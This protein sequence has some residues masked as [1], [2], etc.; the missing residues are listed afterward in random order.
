MLYNLWRTVRS[1]FLFFSDSK[2]G[3]SSF[4]T[5]T[6][7]DARGFGQL[8]RTSFSGQADQR[9]AHRSAGGA[10]VG[11]DRSWH[12]NAVPAYQVNI[13]VPSNFLSLHS[14][15]TTVSQLFCIHSPSRTVTVTEIT[16]G[17]SGQLGHVPPKWPLLSRSV[18]KSWHFSLVCIFFDKHL[19][20]S[21]DVCCGWF[22]TNLL[23]DFAWS[24]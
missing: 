13:L 12:Y 3:T 6:I 4:T 14:T 7:R 23:E 20:D 17:K 9:S 1:F 21:S 19:T 8:K 11:G 15:S 22:L 18:P 10:A 2:N 5:T 16:E 24:L